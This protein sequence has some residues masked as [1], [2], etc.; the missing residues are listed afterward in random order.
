MVNWN[1][2][3]PMIF[4]IEEA[5]ACEHPIMLL[6]LTSPTYITILSDF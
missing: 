4:T 1:D 5:S 2:D 3:T 6:S